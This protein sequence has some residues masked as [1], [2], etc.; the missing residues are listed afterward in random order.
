LAGIK[1]HLQT[2]IDPTPYK[3]FDADVAV[4]KESVF[5]RLYEME[6]S[7]FNNAVVKGVH[8][9]AAKKNSLTF[10]DMFTNRATT[11]CWGRDLLVNSF[12]CFK[13]FF[14]L[15]FTSAFQN[16]PMARVAPVPIAEAGEA[17]STKVPYLTNF[18]SPI[19]NLFVF[20]LTEE[21]YITGP[22]ACA[23]VT[24][25][26]PVQGY[27]FS[28]LDA[29]VGTRWA[30]G[31]NPLNRLEIAFIAADP[32]KLSDFTDP[33]C[34]FDGGDDL[35]ATWQHGEHAFTTGAND[36]DDDS[37]GSSSRSDSSSSDDEG[38]GDRV[39]SQRVKDWASA[40][41]EW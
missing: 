36:G 13:Y 2:F 14:R 27:L 33:K 11:W 25:S 29:I 1:A 18:I 15:S 39:M 17:R 34:I 38:T 12:G 22:D 16:F 35:T 10:A 28:S 24:S 5:N 4:L 20:H 40:F 23:P 9:E 8:M 7:C 37:S 41:S 32:E 6:L 21:Q 19:Y 26:V 31:R 3:C 30:M